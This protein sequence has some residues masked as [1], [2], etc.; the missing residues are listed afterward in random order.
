MALQ[1]FS[2]CKLDP[3]AH[4]NYLYGQDLASN[5]SLSA[6][7]KQLAIDRPV[8]VQEALGRD[9][10]IAAAC[11]RSRQMPMTKARSTKLNALLTGY[12]N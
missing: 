4:T 10:P 2:A 8:A 11:K 7:Q 5:L 1:G 12:H 9:F 6:D 3:F